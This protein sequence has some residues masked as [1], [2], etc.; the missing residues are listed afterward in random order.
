[1]NE[2]Y[3]RKL[4]FTCPQCGG[5]KLD[6]V[7]DCLTAFQEVLAVFESGEVLP[8]RPMGILEDNG[9]WYRCH[10]CKQSLVDWDTDDPVWKDDSLLVDWLLENCPQD[11][12]YANDESKES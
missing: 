12:G 2:K 10:D 9:H 6:L 11:E 5:H 8:V 4:E 7:Y 3:S 1:M